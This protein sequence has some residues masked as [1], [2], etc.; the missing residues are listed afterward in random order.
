MSAIPPPESDPL[1]IDWDVPDDPFA[2]FI[3]SYYAS[4]VLLGDHTDQ[5]GGALFHRMLFVQQ[6]AALE[7]YLGDTLV[8]AVLDDPTAIEALVV[9][10]RDLAGAKFTLAEVAG[11]PDLLRETVKAHLKRVLYHNLSKV[12]FLYRTALQ[13]PIL[14]QQDENDALFRAI[15]LR[16]D[17]VHRNGFNPDGLKHTVFTPAFVR[18]I[19]ELFHKLVNRVEGEVRARS[20]PLLAPEE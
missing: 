20:K 12:D 7:A 4:D 5:L 19:S 17:C 16:H 6:C 18:N 1:W 10:D 13:V 9:T 3:D 15:K 8:R 14:S 2:I 11:R